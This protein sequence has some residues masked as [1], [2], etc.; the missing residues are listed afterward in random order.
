MDTLDP[1]EIARIERDYCLHH[2]EEAAAPAFALAA[3]R[4]LGMKAGAAAFFLRAL[5]PHRHS[6]GR[7]CGT[8]PY[9]SACPST[10]TC[11]TTAGA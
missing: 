8:A 1:E 10:Q 6:P 7:M 5:W 4:W 11:S 9:G 3:T 2:D